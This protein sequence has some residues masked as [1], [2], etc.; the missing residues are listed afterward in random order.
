MKRLMTLLLA[1][2]LVMA[3]AVSA[4]AIDV[5]LKG[6]IQFTWGWFDNTDLNS[7]EGDGTF[8]ARQRE[9]IFVDF[10][11][12]ENVKG[13]IAFEIGETEWGYS[14]GGVGK[15]SGGSLGADGVSVEVKRAYITFNVPNTD[16]IIQPGIQNMALPGAVMGSPI[17]DDDVAGIVSS[18]QFNEYVGLALF[19]ARP[20]NSDDSYDDDDGSQYDE[21]RPVR[22]HGA[23]DLRRHLQRHSL[24]HVRQQ[25]FRLR[26]VQ[27]RRPEERGCRRR[28]R[29]QQRRLPAPVLGR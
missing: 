15:G 28:H 17:L 27:R 5:N 16:L 21:D 2:G 23:R 13:T 6:E 22:C 9:R 4:Y 10:V 12:S 19:W 14:G 1:V 18:Y 29:G 7:N 26:S 11:A 24:L 8:G 20:W 3:F 25:R